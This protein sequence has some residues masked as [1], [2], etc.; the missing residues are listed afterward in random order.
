MTR[1]LQEQPDPATGLGRLESLALAAVHA[2]CDTPGKIFTSVAGADTP[3]QFWGDTML[4]AKINALAQ[5]IPPL[6]QI[7]GPAERLPQ[8]ESALP[9]KD[10]RIKA[11]PSKVVHLTPETSAG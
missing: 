9:L 2:G 8:W 1:W 4:W 7:E 5:R 6:V 3:P 11:V 10:F